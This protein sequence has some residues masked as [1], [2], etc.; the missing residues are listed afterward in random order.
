MYGRENQRTSV[1]QERP[2]ASGP[3]AAA[4]H[5]EDDKKTKK[6]L[7]DELAALRQQIRALEPLEGERKTIEAGTRQ[8]LQY[9]LTASPAIIYTNKASG[10]FA[11][12]F[13]SENLRAIMGYT[14]EEM[15]TDPKCWSD[16]LHPEDA[17]RS[18][19]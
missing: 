2:S 6:Q 4:A 19:R 15:T 9:L 7:L 8:R 3:Q 14:P 11:C 12:T 13:V 10:D 16:H 17:P 5:I 18:L 1:K